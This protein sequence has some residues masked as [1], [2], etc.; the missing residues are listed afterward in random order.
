MSAPR[1]GDV[2]TAAEVEA[3]SLRDAPFYRFVVNGNVEVIQTSHLTVEQLL[4]VPGFA[5]TRWR[6][7]RETHE[8]IPLFRA[9]DDAAVQACVDTEPAID[10]Y[11]D[12]HPWLWVTPKGFAREQFHASA[13]TA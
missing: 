10:P 4:S 6:Y 7:E 5:Q 1:R 8:W 2:Y 3:L 11:G 12:G 13:T 9:V